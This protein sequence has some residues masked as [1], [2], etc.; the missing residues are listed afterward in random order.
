M[1]K[2]SLI[3]IW[4]KINKIVGNDKISLN[5]G[6]KYLSYITSITSSIIKINHRN[7]I[8]LFQTKEIMYKLPNG[9]TVYP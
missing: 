9:K 1:S 8:F 2:W 6:I 5:L 3:E 7:S 4:N